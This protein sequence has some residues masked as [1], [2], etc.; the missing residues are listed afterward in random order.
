MSLLLLLQ[1][2]AASGAGTATPDGVEMTLEVGQVVATGGSAVPIP[3][4]AAMGGGGGGG[5]SFAPR[6]QR[7]AYVRAAEVEPDGVEL[8]AEVGHVFATGGATAQPQGVSMTAD[9]GDVTATGIQNLSD[10]AW[11]LLLDEAA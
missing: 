7:Q 2:A 4:V 11:I 8:V 3:V 9:V 5:S 10:A 6:R 1:S